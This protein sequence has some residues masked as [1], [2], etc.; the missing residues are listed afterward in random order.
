MLIGRTH[1]LFPQTPHTQW[2]VYL[3]VR[4]RLILIMEHF[5]RPKHVLVKTFRIPFPCGRPEDVVTYLCG[6]C[7]SECRAIDEE[8][9]RQSPWPPPRL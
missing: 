5:L 6:E 4:E 9:R 8:I 7:E 1:T 2:D 3:V